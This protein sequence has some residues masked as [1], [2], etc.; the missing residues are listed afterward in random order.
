[1]SRLLEDPT[2]HPLCWPRGWIRTVAAD[3]KRATFGT[4][5]YQQRRVPMTITTAMARL[6][7]E[8]DRLCGL[9]EPSLVVS[10][11]VPVRLDGTLRA[12]RHEPEDPGVALYFRLNDQ[13]TV[14]AC[15]HW[16]RV[17]DNLAAIAAHLEALRGIDRWGVGT[18]AQVFSGYAR[19]PEAPTAKEWWLVLAISPQATWDEIDDAHK[20][21]AQVYHPD[22]G[23]NADM[24]A[25]IN[26]AY[27][28]AKIAVRGI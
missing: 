21:L 18:T 3:R 28:E 19:L 12:D 9:L 13:P 8:C 25:I 2:R 24:M 11:N 7:Y 1:M 20:T 10:T 27:A 17:A 16:T 4:K 23:G 14:L 15:D 5:A 22:R 26:A 6:A